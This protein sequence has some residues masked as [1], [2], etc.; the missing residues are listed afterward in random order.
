LTDKIMLAL[1]AADD[2]AAM[3]LALKLTIARC[4][5]R[6]KSAEARGDEETAKTLAEGRAIYAKAHRAASARRPR[7]LWP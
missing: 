4:S 7:P 5:D 1:A 6:I 3:H 2:V